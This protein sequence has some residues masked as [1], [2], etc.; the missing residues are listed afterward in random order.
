[1]FWL[2][3][4]CLS[5]KK[6]SSEQRFESNSD[7]LHNIP[8]PTV[9]SSVDF[10]PPSPSLYT[11][12]KGSSVVLLHNSK[13]PLINISIILPGGYLHD[14]TLWGRADTAASLLLKSTKKNDMSE[15]SMRLREQGVQVDVSLDER[16]TTIDFI[17]HKE[18]L[19]AAL[20]LIS[21][22]IFE[23][24][25]SQE[26]WDSYIEYR[27]S[28]LIQN[29]EDASKLASTIQN[30]VLYPQKHPLHRI[31][32]G[33]PKHLSALKRKNVEEWH[34]NR[35]DP[36]QVGII[37]VGDIQSQ[38][39][40]SSLNTHL[41]QWSETRFIQPN[42]DWSIPSNTG[43]FLVDV[44]EE[45]Q[46]NLRVLIPNTEEHSFEKDLEVELLGVAMGGSFTS[47]LN[48]KLREEKGYTY[49][50]FC[51]FKEKHV[52]S[53]FFA[54]TSVRR[55]ATSDALNDLL[56]TL[57][58]AQNGFSSEEWQKSK[59]TFRNDIVSQ[60]ESRNNT[61]SA[62]ESNW[63]HQ[64]NPAHAQQQLQM[65]RGLDSAAPTQYADRFSYTKGVVLITGDAKQIET[66][67]STHK[68]I[69]VDITLLLP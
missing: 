43:F 11:T 52:G 58:S 37:A 13:L 22:M 48:N 68:I 63:K 40:L 8:I 6:I 46:T 12:E 15:Q 60:Y 7:P 51:S 56:T 49:G 64:H 29:Y 19:N 59:N 47:R 1:M 69:P 23:P 25:F 38:E 39:L 41:N 45:Q 55:D 50:A 30:L 24:L 67:L 44:P 2:F 3:L 20:P 53:L 27:T 66:T 33:S 18:K 16:Y 54:N 35:L 5:P 4:A 10:S 9:S 42:L 36:S 34:Y 26:E 28:E 31:S 65:I 32:S 57:D 17:V 14:D 61:I 21:D 62:L